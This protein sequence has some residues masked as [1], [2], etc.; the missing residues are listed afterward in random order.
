[1]WLLI[2]T[3][4]LNQALKVYTN[5]DIDFS[6]NISVIGFQIK[7]IIGI[8]QNFHIGASLI[9]NFFKCV[10]FQLVFKKLLFVSF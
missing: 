8:G 4:Y 7:I 3:F 1:M 5:L 2:I 9:M 6:A 10:L